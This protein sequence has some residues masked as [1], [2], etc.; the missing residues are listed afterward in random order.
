[1]AYKFPKI[2]NNLYYYY[3]FIRKKKEEVISISHNN[4]FNDDQPLI[5]KEFAKFENKQQKEQEEQSF[6]ILEKLKICVRAR[7]DSMRLEKDIQQTLP[8]MVS[9]RIPDIEPD[10]DFEQSR[11]AM[12]LVIVVDNS[13]SM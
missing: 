8:L 4:R 11:T 5:R 7:Y 1:M 10:A 13:G 6:I 2:P 3:F 9:V 12:D